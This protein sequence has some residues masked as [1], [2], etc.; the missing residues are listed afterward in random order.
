MEAKEFAKL[1]GGFSTERR[2]EIISTL[3]EAGP[4][5]ITFIELSRKTD[6]SVIDI[7]NAAEALLLMDLIKIS[8]KG[9]NKVLIANFK[10]LDSLFQQ[11]QDTFG[12]DR[13]R[14]P[15]EVALALPLASPGSAA[16]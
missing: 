8:I 3:I 5:G 7:G 13:I 4:G 12:P 14:P 1:F 11:A 6:L 10:L 16:G 9:E 15:K 2:V